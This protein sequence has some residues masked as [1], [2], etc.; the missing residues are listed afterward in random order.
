MLKK[1]TLYHN[2]E[3]NSKYKHNGVLKPFENKRIYI[4]TSKSLL[5]KFDQT[6]FCQ[7]FR[8]YIRFSETSFNQRTQQKIF[9]FVFSNLS[10]VLYTSLS[11]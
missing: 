9:I 2:I 3:S 6:S 4:V 11:Y 7:F 8:T 5:K 1:I 10:F